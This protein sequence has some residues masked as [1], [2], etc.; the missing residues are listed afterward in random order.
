VLVG[1]DFSIPLAIIRIV[2]LNVGVF[3]GGIVVGDVSESDMELPLLRIVLTKK[4][5]QPSR[6]SFILF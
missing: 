3:F 1:S 6:L 2:L 4:N 5:N